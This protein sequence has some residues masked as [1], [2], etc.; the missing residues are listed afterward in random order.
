LRN[1]LRLPVLAFVFVLG[2][3]SLASFSQPPL[4]D[5]A[6]S[7]IWVGDRNNTPISPKSGEAFYVCATVKNIGISLAEGYYVQPYFGGSPL[8]AG[9][10]GRLEAGGAQDWASG[11]IIVGPG[12][13][14]IRWVVNPDHKVA[15][16]NYGNNE[17]LMII[18]IESS[19]PLETML[20]PVGGVVGLMVLVLVVLAIGMVAR[21]L[22][23]K[24]R[25]IWPTVPGE[26]KTVNR[27][28]IP[29]LS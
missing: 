6:I 23:Q 13:Y 18:V 20:R 15:E 7:K 25:K 29:T 27:A 19:S 5:L 12:I 11:P 2:A 14:E 28:P 26:S 10:P 17:I 16:V 1:Y 8:A 9:G 22:V 24:K 21:K 4:P 3:T